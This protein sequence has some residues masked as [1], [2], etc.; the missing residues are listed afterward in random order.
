MITISAT[1]SE[2]ETFSSIDLEL[3]DELASLVS[4]KE[5]VAEFVL[6]QV[7]LSVGGAESP[8]EGESF[9][10]LSEDY[11]EK[12]I[13]E[14]GTPVPNLELEGDML[15]ALDYRITDVGFD[16]G[17]FGTS[18]AWKADGHLN[19]SGLSQ[20]PTRRFLPGEGQSFDAPIVAT[21]EDIINNFRTNFVPEDAPD[22]IDSEEFTALTNFLRD[23]ASPTQ[24]AII[25]GRLETITSPVGLY[26]FL[27][28]QL[29]LPMSVPTDQVRRQVLR[30][31]SLFQLIEAYN[32][33]RFL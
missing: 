27:R 5:E 20:I 25:H 21:V 1:A 6:E 16:I 29:R 10:S 26:N 23:S 13:G 22:G 33:Q 2:T 11:T 28:D 18:E 14:G 15:S 30:N 3:P 4:L 7:L 9:P 19:F 17:F 32:L 31:S 24:L 12:K 8:V